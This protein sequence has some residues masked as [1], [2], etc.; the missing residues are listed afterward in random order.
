VVA[1]IRGAGLP[2][3]HADLDA[4]VRILGGGA[5]ERLGPLLKQLVAEAVSWPV[6]WS[7]H[8]LGS[9]SRLVE[10]GMAGRHPELSSEAIAA[11]A[12]EFSYSNR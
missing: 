11:L 12:W 1:Y 2:H 5:A 6:D 9:A 3:P 7:L 4:V 10:E 8:D